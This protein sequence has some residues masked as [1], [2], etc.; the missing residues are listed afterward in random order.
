VE[1]AR[2]LK[3]L[4][5]RDGLTRLLTHTACQERAKALVAE[6]QRHPGRPA[7]WVMVDLDHF[8]MINDRHGHPTGDKVLTS[9]AA[10]LRRRLRQSDT[11][12]R[13]GGEEFVILLEDL[14]EPQALRLVSRL[15]G[16]FSALQH[17][18]PDGAK[19][20]ATFSAGVA[21]LDLVADPD[22]TAERWKQA[23]DDALYRAKAAGRNRVTGA[24]A[25]DSGASAS[26]PG[27]LAGLG[28]PRGRAGPARPA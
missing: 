10:L 14:D 20:H 12:A 5:E 4:L 27:I 22:A 24:P 17:S 19:F 7:A 23:A 28:A 16:E 11:V 2:F 26:G 3:S 1:R 6:R 8:K 21:M 25:P 13:Y 18:G 9:L 15:L